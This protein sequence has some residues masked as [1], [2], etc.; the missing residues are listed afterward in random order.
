MPQP[1]RSCYCPTA[2]P[3]RTVPP[4]AQS[5]PP[6]PG[7]AELPSDQG[8]I[9]KGWRELIPAHGQLTLCGQEERHPGQAPGSCRQHLGTL[10]L[11]PESSLSVLGLL[12]TPVA[13]SHR[14]PS[15]LA[16]FRHP[17]APGLS[18]AAEGKAVQ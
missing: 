15:G 7:F 5:H 4:P 17:P 12:W 13:K 8:P 14:S 9:G 3:E 11:F 6:T 10:S 16:R 18:L 2:A 1:L